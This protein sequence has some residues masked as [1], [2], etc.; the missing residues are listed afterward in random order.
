[1]LRKGTFETYLCFLL[2]P[3]MA[4]PLIGVQIVRKDKN[5]FLIL[6]ILIGILSFLYIPNLVDD[7]AT[8]Y[9][10][11]E[12]FVNYT[13]SDFQYYLVATKRP[14]FIFESLI[15]LFS[16]LNLNIQYLFLFCTSFISFSIFRFIYTMATLK[17][18]AVNFKNV[19]LLS[20]FS[21]SFLTL[22]SG[23]RF[24]LATSVLLFAFTFFLKFGINKKFIVLMFITMQIHFSMVVFIVIF[25]ALRYL[26]T[27]QI[28]YL[29]YF[30]FLLMFFSSKLLDIA[31]SVLSFSE[32]YSNKV[33]V[34]TDNELTTVSENA[35]ILNRIRNMWIYIAMLFIIAS[36][37][38]NFVLVKVLMLLCVVLNVVSSVPMVF[39]RYSGLFKI[40]FIGYFLWYSYQNKKKYYWF[41]LVLFISFFIDFYLMR[42]N[43]L[44][45]LNNSSILTIVNILSTEVDFGKFL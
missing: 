27:K 25:L 24:Y 40:F 15:F 36:K 35:S 17:G 6:A 41:Y 30:S 26:N 23:I 5:V 14:D 9:E 22:F 7:K 28:T 8:Y 10:R 21:L 31:G 29:F 43:F 18:D 1:M 19:V 16:K 11:Y 44:E 4:I 39:N 13:F 45:T 12:V 2:S 3:F 32:S 34:Y 42:Y 33:N 20:L 38:K 37:N